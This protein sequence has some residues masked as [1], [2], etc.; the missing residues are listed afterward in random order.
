MLSLTA[1]AQVRLRAQ[2][3]LEL[4]RRPTGVIELLTCRAVFIAQGRCGTCVTIVLLIQLLVLSRSLVVQF[5]NP[6]A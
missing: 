6:F 2:R 4:R 5:L 1:R 3:E